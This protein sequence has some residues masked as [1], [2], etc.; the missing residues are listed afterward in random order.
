MLRGNLKYLA[1]MLISSLVAASPMIISAIHDVFFSKP[2]VYTEFNPP[3]LNPEQ[4]YIKHS[5]N[6][7][8]IVKPLSWS[9]AY[10]LAAHGEA[11]YR[12]IAYFTASDLKEAW[13][14][15]F[16]YKTYYPDRNPC[17][18]L[19]E[20]GLFIEKDLAENNCELL[21][22][23]TL[24]NQTTWYASYALIGYFKKLY[25]KEAKPET[26][27]LYVLTIRNPWSITV[28]I[29]NVLNS[30]ELEQLRKDLQELVRNKK[31]L[32][33]L[34]NRAVKTIW[35]KEFETLEENKI[36]YVLLIPIGEDKLPEDMDY[37]DT[38]ELERK[39]YSAIDER[40]RNAVTQHISP[41]NADGFII[42]NG[43]L[44]IA[45]GT[46]YLCKLVD[47]IKCFD[48]F[49]EA[50]KYLGYNVPT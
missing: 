15:I 48:S 19:Y 35:M 10:S 27:M 41:Y 34:H 2:V 30:K 45:F 8:E 12:Y 5:Y 42:E 46:H 49:V 37:S 40:L 28:K 4:F 43:K 36:P 24:S 44:T 21:R 14:T 20:E 29:Y 13:L 7:Y 31:L 11:D 22:K 39:L 9:Q 1:I 6:E 38:M 18:M 23:L 3:P 26:Y 32:V 47:D 33:I 25:L 17:E 16:Y 50:I